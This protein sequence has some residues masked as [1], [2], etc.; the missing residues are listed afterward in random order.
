M[1]IID[2]GAEFEFDY[3]LLEDAS[4]WVMKNRGRG[5]T[6]PRK[7]PRSGEVPDWRGSVPGFPRPG[8]L[9]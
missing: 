2:G 3:E 1:T 8:N 4:E 9:R 6:R 7:R 5:Q